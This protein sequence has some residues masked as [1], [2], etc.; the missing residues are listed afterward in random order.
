MLISQAELEVMKNRYPDEKPT[1][2]NYMQA[3]E[4]FL[5]LAAAYT[6]LLDGSCGSAPGNPS[7]QSD[8]KRF[9]V[10]INSDYVRDAQI[11]PGDLFINDETYFSDIDSE[12]EDYEASML[13]G[14]FMACC[15]AEAIKSAADNE[16]IDAKKL[17]AFQIV[18]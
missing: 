1:V 2:F 3:R 12:W 9:L 6:A 16:N 13:V 8:K 18:D 7:G 14:Q 15:A 4:D 5:R 17:I 11:L 10:L